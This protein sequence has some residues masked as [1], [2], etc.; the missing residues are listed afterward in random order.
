M[1]SKQP[2]QMP[3]VVLFGVSAPFLWY[4]LP[5]F[6]KYASHYS[7]CQDAYR[8]DHARLASHAEEVAFLGGSETEALRIVQ[9]FGVMMK[10]LEE[11]NRKRFMHHVVESYFLQYLWGGVE[12]ALAAAPIFVV[13]AHSDP[14]RDTH[15]HDHGNHNHVHGHAKQNSA[16]DHHSPTNKHGHSPSIVENKVHSHSHGHSHSHTSSVP[17]SRDV[18]PSTPAGQFIRNQQLVSQFTNALKGSRASLFFAERGLCHP[19]Y[20]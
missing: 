14:A 6:G 13:K 16:H 17:S 5:S 19:H 3:L 12:Y 9:S 20:T 8:G 18:N 1:G 10:S 15:E 4:A 2:M 11:W 7:H